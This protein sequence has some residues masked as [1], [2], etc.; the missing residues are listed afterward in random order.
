[1]RPHPNA[2]FLRRMR[3]AIIA[4][5]L[6]SLAPAAAADERADRARGAQLV[7]RNCAGCHAVG[8]SDASRNPAAPPFRELH[9][10]YEI[11]HLAEALVEGMLAGH[12]AMPE[13]RFPPDDVAAIIAYLKSIQTQ[14]TAGAR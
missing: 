14:Q 5:A 10:R 3:A 2:F 1:M 11:D 6:L 8:T 13:F 9:R 7:Q 12:P 4:L